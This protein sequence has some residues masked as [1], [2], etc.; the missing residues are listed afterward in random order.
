MGASVQKRAA[1]YTTGS[2]HRKFWISKTQRLVCFRPNEKL[3]IVRV[4]KDS[5]R[6]APHWPG[7]LCTK[8][9]WFWVLCGSDQE[10]LDACFLSAYIRR[11]I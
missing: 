7:G 8:P 3:T 9:F 5:A 10:F 6:R 1:S 4:S 2:W 11:V